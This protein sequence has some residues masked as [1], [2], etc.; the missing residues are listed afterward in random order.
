[1]N[2]DKLKTYLETSNT[3]ANYKKVCEEL[4]EKVLTGNAKLSQLKELER[5]FKFHK[6]GNKFVFT[7]IYLE[8]KD[9][10][11]GRKDTKGN[12][13]VYGKYIYRTISIRFTCTNISNYKRKKNIFK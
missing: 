12:N 10:I 11:D 13:N 3:L 6:Q 8:P 5:Y 4:D 9:K 2:I 7:E 1:M